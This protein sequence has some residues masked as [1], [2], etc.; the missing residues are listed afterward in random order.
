MNTKKIFGCAFLIEET[1]PEDVFTPEDFSD[2]HRLFA[3]TAEEF[4][5]KEVLP[6]EKDFEEKNFGVLRSLL[7]QSA[8][9]GLLGADVP[10][11]FGGVA[12][13]KV[14]SALITEKLARSSY[15]SVSHE[16]HRGIG[17]YPLL[18]FGTKGQ[19][20][21]YLGRLATAEIIGAY[22][23]TD[24]KAG[25]DAAALNARARLS[26]NGLYYILSGSKIWI[27]NAGFADL[28]TVFAKVD[29]DPKKITAFLLERNFPGLAVGSE[30]HKLGLA[31][32]STCPL[33]FENIYVPRENV[34]GE[35]GQGFKIAMN[36]LNLGRFKLGAGCAGAAKALLSRTT[37]EAKARIAFGHRITDFGLVKEKF[38]EMAARLWLAESMTYR[39]AGLLDSALSEIP[40]EDA[41]GFMSA[42]AGFA[43]ECSFNKVF[44]SET[45]QYVVDECLQI[46]GGMGFAAESPEAR[47]YRDTRVNRIFEG[48]NEVNRL[49]AADRIIKSDKGFRGTLPLFEC[50]KKYLDDLLGGGLADAMSDGE[51]LAAETAA[52]GNFKKLTVLLLGASVQKFL[53]GIGD[54]E[55]VLAKISDCAMNVFALESGLLRAKKILAAGKKADVECAIVKLAAA[56]AA[57]GISRAAREVAGRISCGDELRIQKSIIRKLTKYEDEGAIALRRMVADAYLDGSFRFF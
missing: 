53:A 41:K 20:E 17:T 8:E 9:L 24:E 33:T 48:T 39:L 30:E 52:L 10:E 27:T 2:E 25:S 34:L 29:G 15:F 50:A 5:K 28:F 51:S 35:V 4:V 13:D 1:L 7:R 18:L 37:P 57:Q 6:R 42:V 40:Q 26:E 19:K 55:E 23:L 49:S 54:E 11:A 3:Q 21:K 22:A 47:A 56:D 44:G 12:A 46:R 38:A 16:A 14:A 45:L 43:A 32:S 36:V 31:G